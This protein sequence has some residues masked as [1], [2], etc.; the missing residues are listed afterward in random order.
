MIELDIDLIIAYRLTIEEYVLLDLMRHRWTAKI[1]TY[2]SNSE[3]LQSLLQ[4]LVLLGHL[5]FSA[6]GDPNNL[7]DY[8]VKH[9][10]R[11]RDDVKDNMVKELMEA[12]PVKVTRPDG[13]TDYLKSNSKI[14]K[15][16]YKKI[17]KGNKSTHDH[18]LACLKL[19]LHEVSRTGKL[20]Y[21][22]KL[23]NWLEREEWREWEDKLFNTPS[24]DATGIENS[25]E[26]SNNIYGNLL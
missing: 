17:I 4:R 9:F 21:L 23:T 8:T 3:H 25:N 10:P 2:F 20:P 22:R 11:F 26:E 19:Q 1:R 6:F 13:S 14:I 7:A 18:I 24:S 5:K 16:A 12:Y 15:D